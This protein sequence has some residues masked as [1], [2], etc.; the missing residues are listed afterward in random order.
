MSFYRFYSRT[1]S[2]AY[3]YTYYVTSTTRVA[4]NA[5]GT[6]TLNPYNTPL[7]RLKILA[8]AG[9]DTI[10]ITSTITAGAFVY[11]GDGDDTIS[12][13]AGNDF[14][15]GEAGNDTILAGGGNDYLYGGTGVDSLKGQDGNDR[16]WGNNALFDDNV[17]DYLYGGS[18]S[19][20]FNK[21]NSYFWWR[22]LGS[23]VISDAVAT[24][25]VRY[26]YFRY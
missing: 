26:S 14:I 1:Y 19:D 2:Y 21:R 11:G 3:T 8:G 16:L 20:T 10:S 17:V 9:N 13:G 12:T 15:Y 18:G 24:R 4:L 22:S 25:V 6:T 7:S 5:N 23:D